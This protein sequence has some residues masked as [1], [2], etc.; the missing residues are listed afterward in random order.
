MAAAA[1]IMNQSVKKQHVAAWQR[2]VARRGGISIISSQLIS[3]AGSSVACGMHQ[4]GIKSVMTG[5]CGSGGGVKPFSLL[6]HHQCGSNSMA[7]HG[8]Y[9]H[10]MAMA[11]TIVAY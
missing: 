11:W 10:V 2:G 8:M 7:W 9:H 6:H 3:V 1:A 5:S 4:H